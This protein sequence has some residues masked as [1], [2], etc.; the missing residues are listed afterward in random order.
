MKVKNL[1]FDTEFTSLSK[2][3]DLISIGIFDKNGRCFYAEITDFDR[4]LCDDWIKKNVIDNCLFID[5]SVDECMATKEKLTTISSYND[6][7]FIH[8]TKEKVS[9]ALN[10]WLEE[11]SNYQIEFVSDVCSY[12]FVLLVDLITNGKSSLDLPKNITPDCYNISQCIYDEYEISMI[13]AFNITRED[14]LNDF[15]KNKFILNSI[16]GEA[17]HNSLWDAYVIMII[18]EYNKGG[19]IK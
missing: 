7:T 17:K 11:Y 12:D 18:S 2:N 3:A 9:K 15:D 14:Y 13:D 8:N 5:K 1:Y 19:I 10:L 16:I 4:T 6:S